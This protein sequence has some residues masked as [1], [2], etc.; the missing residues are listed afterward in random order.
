VPQSGAF[1][2]EKWLKE[3]ELNEGAEQAPVFP[4]K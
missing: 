1:D 3:G 4:K 2:G